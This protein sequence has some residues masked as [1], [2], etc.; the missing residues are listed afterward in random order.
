MI[1]ETYVQVIDFTPAGAD[2]FDIF[3]AK[4]A[5]P[6]INSRAYRLEC[7]GVIE[8]RINGGETA[9]WELVKPLSADGGAATF[10][11]IEDDLILEVV[12]MSEAIE[13]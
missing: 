3:M 5:L 9:E 6:G 10:R 11:A 2:K 8:E 4:H 13:L 7:L 12:A 1:P